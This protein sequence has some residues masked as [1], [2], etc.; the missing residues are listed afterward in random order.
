MSVGW[1]R[2]AFKFG[3]YYKNCKIDD[4]WYPPRLRTR[5][6]MFDGFDDRTRRHNAVRMNPDW[7]T[8]QDRTRPFVVGQRS[9]LI[10]PAPVDEMVPIFR[11]A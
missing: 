1:A 10:R 9:K 7:I 4:M 3:E 11:R 8:F 6:W 5:E 2:Y